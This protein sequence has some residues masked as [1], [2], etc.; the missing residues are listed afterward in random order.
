MNLKAY[1]AGQNNNRC[2]FGGIFRN[3]IE[4]KKYVLN[5]GMLA[6]VDYVIFKGKRY[7]IGE[8]YRAW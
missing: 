4:A 6:A 7:S 8:V 1:Q 2:L 5:H 3:K